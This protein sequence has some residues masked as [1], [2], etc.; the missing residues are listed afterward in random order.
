MGQATSRERDK[1]RPHGERQARTARGA[2]PTHLS[3]VR[4][5]GASPLPHFERIPQPIDFAVLRP[6]ELREEK[7][8]APF[9]RK[10]KDKIPEK[11][12]QEGKPFN[13]KGEL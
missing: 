3:P 9:L 6:D 4:S 12:L 7:E 11:I 13:L 1:A 8:D 5:V 10:W 2:V